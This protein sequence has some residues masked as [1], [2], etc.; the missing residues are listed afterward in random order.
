MPTQI[1]LALAIVSA[2]ATALLAAEAGWRA[3]RDVPR[4][5]LSGW[6]SAAQLIA[7]GV[8][9]IAGL[10]LVA[11]GTQPQNTIHYLLAVAALIAVPG[12]QTFLTRM[13][14]RLRAAIV[15]V[16]ALLALGAVALLFMTG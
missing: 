2:V 7:V 12:V 10:G 11:L 4:A 14:E 6:L 3:L 15:C 5:P 16:T 9:S 1:H 13:G 8:T